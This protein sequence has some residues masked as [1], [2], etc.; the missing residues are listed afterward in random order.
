MPVT[1]SINIIESKKI[2]FT[3]FVHD[4]GNDMGRIIMIKKDRKIKIKQ[5]CNSCAE[6]ILLSVRQVSCFTVV[7]YCTVTAALPNVGQR[8][9]TLTPTV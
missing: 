1:H 2:R 4:V 7:L 3:I 9:F 8:H 5:S 6:N